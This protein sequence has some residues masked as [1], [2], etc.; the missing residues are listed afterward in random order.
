MASSKVG[1]ANLALVKIGGRNIT[2]FNENSKEAKAILAVY[3]DIRDEVLGEHPWSFAQKRA[4]LAVLAIT[5]PMTEDGMTIAYAK[6]SDLIRISAVSDPKA[7]Y[8]F[9]SYGILSN[10]ANL[11]IKYTYRNDDPTKYLS[12]F[13]S[14]LATR[15]AS[16]IAFSIVESKT[17]AANLLEEYEE[18]RLPRAK[19]EDSQQ[20]TPIQSVQDEWEIARLAGSNIAT[21]QPGQQTWHPW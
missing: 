2:S 13:V 9:E 6:P 11:K 7:T 14:A 20:S 17:I 3:D 18:L 16:A 1:I 21:P 19:S 12:L 8:K 4:G 5:I 10:T 15:L